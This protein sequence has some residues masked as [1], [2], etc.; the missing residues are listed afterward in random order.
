MGRFCLVGTLVKVSAQVDSIETGEPEYFGRN[1][2]RHG[3]AYKV[4]DHAG[5]LLCTADF[6]DG[7][8][9]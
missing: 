3:P 2:N 8:E 6:I 4:P 9:R 5:R 7:V 1:F